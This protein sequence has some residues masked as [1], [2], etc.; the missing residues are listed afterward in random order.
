MSEGFHAALARARDLLRRRQL[1]RE[2]DEEM[3]FHLDAEIARN[4][5]RGLSPDEARRAAV[6]A[7]GGVQRFLEDTRE[8]RGLAAID[9]IARDVRLALR[10]L[11]RAPAFTAGTVATLA[12]GVGA[13]SGIGALVYGVLLRPLPYRDPDRLVRLSI[14][15]P[16]LGI[17]S[18]E[19]S[20]GTFVYFAERA[21]SFRTL[22]AYMENE[23]VAITD[24][25]APE[26]ATAAIVTPDVLGLLGVTPV[27]GRLFREEDAGAVSVTASPV[28]IS[29]D[30]WQRRFGAHPDVAARTIEL[31]RV[32]RRI[33]GVLPRGF[34]FPSRHTSIYFVDRVEATHAGLGDRYLTVIGRLA[35]GVTVTQAQE[36]LDQLVAHLP[37]R[38]PELTADAL[39]QAGLRSRVETMRSAIVAPVRPEL[40]LLAIMMAVLLLITTANVATLTLLRAERLR[41]QVAVARA[42]GAHGAAVTQRFVVEGLVLA[43]GGAV[44]ACPIVVLAVSAKFGFTDG[45]IPRLH[46]VSLTPALFFAML[47][48]AVA[49]GLGL[50]ALSAVRAGGGVAAD[51]LRGDSRATRGRG[52]KRTQ[53]G[54]VVVQIAVALTLLLAAGVA[55]K[56]LFRLKRIDL[57]FTPRH[58]ATFTIVLP[59]RAYP[60]YQRTAAFDLSVLEALR[61][62]PGVTA[63]A[64]AMQFPS[65]PQ[66]L[67]AHPRLEATRESGRSAQALVTANVVSADFFRVLGIPLRAGRTFAPGDLAAPTP[68]VVLS[69][70]LAHELFDT[71]NPIGREVRIASGSRY[72]PYRVVGVSGDVYGDRLIDGVLRVIYFPLLGD[73]PPTSTETEQRIPFMP[74]GMHLVVRST[75]PMAALVPEFRRAVSSVD[76]RVPL[77]DPRTLDAI[78]ADTTGRTRL[79]MLLLAIAA[80]ATLFLGV[81][82]LYS[83]IAYGVEGRS[84][85]FA[86]RIAL[87]CT[88]EAVRRLVVLEGLEVAGVGLLMGV[89]ASIAEGRMLR[90]VLYEVSATDPVAY[91]AAG[92]VVLLSTVLATYV[93]ALRAAR[94]D[95]VRALRAE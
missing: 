92:L 47:G 57:G 35:A 15:T 52:W 80:A 11:R 31:N 58:G 23:G 71:E 39:R 88:P 9:A 1:D 46:D 90:G 29:Y 78:V 8:A 60:T 77:W 12:L 89:L 34:D 16:G 94:G 13:A 20:S 6:L 18:T 59:F 19:Q 85:E 26:R 74:A 72:P 33:A 55:G 14:T 69:R 48:V 54:L 81:I 40:T 21:R 83:V 30:L 42:L 95:P 50:G 41:G 62:T 73:L 91:V 64:A 84:R 67:Y 75:L 56:S 43:L 10:R 32:P 66:L 37:D 63:V 76:P 68:G 93:P 4:V 38:Y 27:A 44:V 17:T 36:E 82:G 7:F 87:G 25:D 86:V 61:R 53:E 65:T 45:Q 70:S 51:S 79:T 49:I 28:L 22:G 24:G 5:A 3:R 2:L